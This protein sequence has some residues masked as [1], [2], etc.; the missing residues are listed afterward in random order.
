MNTRAAARTAGILFVVA[1]GAGIAAGGLENRVRNDPIDLASVATHRTSLESAATQELIMAVAC[2]TI[3]VVLYPVLRRWSERLALGYVV[4]RTVEGVLYAISV[5]GLLT[6]VAL[7]REGRADSRQLAGL[8]RTTRDWNNFALLYMTFAIS[9]AVLSVALYRSVLVPRWL[10]GWGIVG[11][12]L[13]FASGLAV[14]FGLAAD[15]STQTAGAAALAAQE[16]VLA[17]WLI[18]RGFDERVRVASRT[19][20]TPSLTAGKR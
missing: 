4:C 18:V 13:Y 12:V 11:A 2:V 1:D 17:I 5:V 3:A 6:V 14:V 10:A 16:L 19:P 15:S 20:D 7:G 9:A 8:V